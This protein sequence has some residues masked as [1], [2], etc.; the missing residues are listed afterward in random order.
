M[1]SLA[2][3]VVVQGLESDDLTVLPIL[4]NSKFETMCTA[5]TFFENYNLHLINIRSNLAEEMGTL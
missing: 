3:S 1:T 4:L 2:D 5:S